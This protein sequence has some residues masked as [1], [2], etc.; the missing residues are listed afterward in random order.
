[1]TLDEFIKDILG[2]DAS[3]YSQSEIEVF[4]ELSNRTFDTVFHNFLLR[5]KKSKKFLA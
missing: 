5:R 4:Y 2:A 1:M 3:K